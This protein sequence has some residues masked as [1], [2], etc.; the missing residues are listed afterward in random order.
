MNFFFLKE[1]T[2]FSSRVAVIKHETLHLIFKHLFKLDKKKYNQ[3]L[4][5]IAADLVVNQFIGKWNLPN[6]AITISSFP[7]LKLPINK[8]VEWYYERIVKL[9]KQ[10]DDQKIK[11][12]FEKEANQLTEKFPRKSVDNLSKILDGVSHSDHS[13]WIFEDNSI[14][15]KHAETELDRLIIQA[16]ERI[17]PKQFS[18]LPDSIKDL[19]EIMIKKRKPE[20][21]WKRALKIFSSSSRKTKIKITSKR[22][23]KRF[24]TR[25]G[26]KINRNQKMAV[27]I[28]TSASISKNELNIIFSEIHSMWTSGAELEIIECDSKIQRVYEFNGNFPRFIVGGGGTCFDPVFNYINRNRSIKYDG[29]IYLTDGFAAEPTIKPTCSL[30]WLITPEGEIGN[31]LKHGRIIKIKNY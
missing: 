27:A 12:D 7:E 19:I 8:S 13:K 16:K 1:L 11:P 17:S 3:K 24:G 18:S 10:L 15:S 30:L 23:S 21:N 26:T 25:P 5:N 29:C 31:H 22:V 28:D 20:V 6:S 14:V 2:T 9:K 4:F